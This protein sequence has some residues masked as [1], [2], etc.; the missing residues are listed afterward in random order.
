MYKVFVNDRPIIFTSSLIKDEDFLVLNYKDIIL[1]D[2]IEQV[3]A[4]KLK[5]VY[6]FTSNLQEIWDKFSADYRLKKAGGGLVVNSQKEVLFI[7]RANKWDLPKGRIEN[8]EDIEETAIREVKE[9]SGIS[10][11]TID[12]FLTNTYHLYKSKGKDRLKKTHWYLMKTDSNNYLAPLLKE[13]I[14]KAAFFDE[15]TIRAKILKRT[16]VNIK[17]VYKLYKDSPL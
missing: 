5:G 11:V 15:E 13:G 7:F 4:G 2:V 6:I 17:T 14:K 9:E 10:Y 12:K 16:Y 8:N 1:K 3:K